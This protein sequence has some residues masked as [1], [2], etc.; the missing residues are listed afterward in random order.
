MGRWTSISLTTA[1]SRK[2][3]IISAY[4]VCQQ[5]SPGTNTAASHQTAHIIT[6]SSTTGSTTRITPRQAFIQDL[7]SF[8]RNMQEEEEDIILVGDF[9]DDIT[10]P[11]SGMDQLATT[12][13]LVDL[14]SVR[15]GSPNL[16]ATYQRGTKRLDFVL[17]SPS[18]IN[19][20]KAA[21][22][23][24]FGYRIPSDHRGMYVDLDTDAV[25]QQPISEMAPADKRDFVSTSPGV[26]TKYVTSK[27]AYLNDHR[28]FD[29]L[30][31]LEGS[32]VPNH[33]LAESLDRDFQRASSHAARS[34]SR[35]KQTPW[36]PKL[37]E[38]WAELH[39]Y[40]LVKSSLRT[41]ANYDPAIKKLQEQWPQLPR[42]IPE[43]QEELHQCYCGAVN[44][45]KQ[46]R[47]EAQTL[48]DEHLSKRAEL[49]QHLEE[50]G[51]AKIVQRLI[52]AESQRRVYQKIRYLRNQDGGT[53]G[54]SSLKIPRN[55]AI[56]E[57][58]EIKR[59]PDSPEYWETITAPQE[60]ESLPLRTGRGDAVHTTTIAS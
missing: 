58:E 31:Q 8:I 18:L 47:Q 9:N 45:L 42:R 4:Q 40:R 35:K 10:D 49:Y 28:F 2:V 51:K 36:S 50:N 7:Q 16:P 1:T 6:E 23:D 30:G 52:R 38:A 25:F 15:T 43:N 34:C 55:V 27:M 19:H 60:I 33:D 13:G 37:A 44:K 20:V 53:L 32:T 46:I 21:G 59:L 54:L 57:T 17:I 41:T 14:F 29:R 26:I 3:R 5:S 24:P 39:L 48:R 56:T 22:Y 11:M 12:C